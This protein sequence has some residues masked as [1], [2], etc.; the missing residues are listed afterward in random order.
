M[1]KLRFQIK[2]LLNRKKYIFLI[3]LS[4]FIIGIFLN[5]VFS[6]NPKKISNN[7]FKYNSKLVF[8]ITFQTKKNSILYFEG[9]VFD[10]QSIKEYQN[11]ISG[12]GY[13]FSNKYRLV[14]INGN[15]SVYLLYSKPLTNNTSPHYGNIDI[16]KSG[17]YAKVDINKL[18]D[19]PYY[20][21]FVNI[22]DL[23]VVYK[24]NV[25]TN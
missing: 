24:T 21:G 25:E 9:Y 13:G 5:V 1:S 20:L 23:K 12:K 8:E 17:F 2:I 15:D 22:E 4:I 19:G 7:E 16:S 18:G 14:L 3:I 11:Y 6:T 10:P